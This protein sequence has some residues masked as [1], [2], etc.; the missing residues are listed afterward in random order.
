MLSRFRFSTPQI[1]WLLGASLCISMGALG[2]SL[3]TEE[4]PGNQPARPP[5]FPAACAAP[6]D[7]IV[8]LQEQV[9]RSKGFQVAG[10]FVYYSA[11]STSTEPDAGPIGIFRVPVT[12]GAPE[13][14]ASKDNL[15]GFWVEGERIF[16]STWEGQLF[17]L[18]QPAG[19]P[20]LVVDA[21]E[22]AEYGTLISAMEEV[23]TPSRFC[24]IAFY[25]R[26]ALYELRCVDR[27]GGKAEGLTLAGGEGGQRLERLSAYGDTPVVFLRSYVPFPD[28]SVLAA[29]KDGTIVTLQSRL[30]QSVMLFGASSDS[31]LLSEWPSEAATTRTLMR[32]DLAEHAALEPLL[33]DSPLEPETDQILVDG[34]QV[35]ASALATFSGGRARVVVDVTSPGQVNDVIAC[36]PYNLQPTDDQPATQTQRMDSG[37]VYTVVEGASGKMGIA[38]RPRAALK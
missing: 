32:A 9:I 29:P 37:Y 4:V 38:R 28:S 7:Y 6:L 36:L 1:R 3:S 20:S 10:G 25:G 8:P 15:E 11:W 17:E 24:V 33:A 12:G 34:A 19:E 5:D 13:L 2:C 23:L 35:F 18:P 27:S 16:Y 31:L 21:M 22:G 14:I 26:N 30:D